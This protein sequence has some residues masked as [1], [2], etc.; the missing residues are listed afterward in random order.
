M[1]ISG[2]AWSFTEQIG[3]QLIQFI[4]G[5]ILARLLLP[6]EFGLIGM[7]AIFIAVSESI[8][9][10]GFVQ[11]LIRK[12]NCTEKDY[13]TAFVFNFSTSL[14]LYGILFLTAPYI[15]DFYNQSQLIYLV[16]VLCIIIIIDAV[17]FVQRAQLY[18]EVNFKVIAK[19]SVL[20]QTI[21]GVS[22]VL[23]ALYGFGVWSLI[24]KMVLNHL[25]MM[26]NLIIL[27]KWFPVFIF[28]KNSFKN[29]FGFGSKILLTQII[30]RMYKNIYFLIIGKYFSATE[31]GYYT[32]SNQFKGIV[33]D[34]LVSSVQ[35]VTLPILSKLQ[36]SPDKL[37]SSFNNLIKMI[38]FI[39]SFFLVGLVAM[40]EPMILFLIGEKWESSILYLQLLAVSAILYPVGDINLN[41]LQVK[42]RSDYILKLQ[43]IKKLISVPVIIIGVILGIK[44]LIIGIIVL[45]VFDFFA[46]S[47]YS[48]RMIN[49]SSFSQLKNS[50][51]SL[52]IISI[53]SGVTFILSKVLTM[54]PNGIVF[55]IQVVFY[56]SVCITIFE[57]FKKWEYLEAKKIILE[58]V[59]KL[60]KT[61]KYSLLN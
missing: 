45:S 31:L 40:A 11:A 20:S 35:R 54:L 41:I 48:G 16:R 34:Q 22:G 19:A 23:A 1:T 9:S 21:S 14:L 60:K 57:L 28:S 7:M 8:S 61:K 58:S 52:L 55:L 5:I 10:G 3:N 24:I 50:L 43:I 6:A 4:I 2:M 18:K 13:N 59:S 33:S 51:P 42:G 53:I 46:N 39:S 49:C 26:I 15:A 30:E 44:Y 37:T 17:A 36:D 25:M 29:L 38:F 47:Y 12:Q 27:N 56:L 32:R